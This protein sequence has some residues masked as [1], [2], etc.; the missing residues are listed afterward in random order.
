MKRVFL[1]IPVL[2][3]LLLSAS[4]QR[5]AKKEKFKVVGYYSLASAAKID[6]KTVPF[7]QMT[8][9]NLYFLN[10]D[11]VGNINQDMSA[12]IPFIKEAH[13]HGVK[14]LPS[15][16]GGSRHPYYHDILET[17]RAMF[18]NN[19][20]LTVLK[21]GFDGVDVDIE[22]ADVDKNYESFVTGLHHVMQTN[23]KLTT[24]AVAIFY[25]DT[26]SEEALA[27]FD[28]VNVMSY[29]HSSPN[30]APGS[31]SSYED[32]V[33][34]LDFFNTVKKVPKEKMTLGVPFYGR[35][36][37]PEA[38]SPRST[39]T[40]TKIL[41]AVPGAELKDRVTMPNG[42]DVY[43]NGIPVMKRKVQLAKEKASGIMIW[44]IQQDDPA[45]DKSLLKAIND[46][47]Y[48]KK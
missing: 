1:L 27:Q 26:E 34:D 8:H 47:A 4:A 25:K 36:F 32:A 40:Y 24:A 6:L 15:I 29:D 37:G 23:H 9:I 10:P 18:I 48:N 2:T 20:L 28:Y 43:Y 39:V 44:Q 14:V 41:E 21:Y 46:E 3:F 22:G 17:K 5:S 38:T 31:H 30:R 13:K 45:P 42:S 19:L 7:D 16:A 35:G 11:T 12:L 33:A